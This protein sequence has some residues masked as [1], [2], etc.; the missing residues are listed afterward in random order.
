MNDQDQDQAQSMDQDVKVYDLDRLDC[1]RQFLFD[2]SDYALLNSHSV[3]DRYRPPLYSTDDF[4]FETTE[5]VKDRFIYW[6]RSL[7]FAK[8]LLEF[9][10]SY[11][12]DISNLKLAYEHQAFYMDYLTRLK[13]IYFNSIH[14]NKIRITTD[15]DFKVFYLFLNQ[16]EAYIIRGVNQT[17]PM[18]KSDLQGKIEKWFYDNM[19]DTCEI[20][21][22]SDID[23]LLIVNFAPYYYNTKNNSLVHC[24]DLS[25]LYTF[26]L[27]M[28]DQD[29]F[30]LMYSRF[31][32]LDDLQVFE[33]Q[34]GDFCEN[35]LYDD[36]VN[37]DD[38][39][40]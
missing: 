23:K 28:F 8:I 5:K 15:Q 9:E 35:P 33:D 25:N 4:L 40:K 7:A 19:N 24:N 2:A 36:G 30:N 17:E 1:I 22:F 27:L 31:K 29:T 37:F 3:L 38:I 20:S 11:I 13:I 16:I 21:N 6:Y 32:D 39:F 34:I 26:E 10:K 18:F 14:E 12:K